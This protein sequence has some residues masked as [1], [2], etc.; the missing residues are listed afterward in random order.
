MTV[1]D[2]IV[3]APGKAQDGETITVMLSGKTVGCLAHD[4]AVH[5]S[6]MS[7]SAMTSWYGKWPS[8]AMASSV[9]L[10]GVEVCYFHCPWSSAERYTHV[11]VIRRPKTLTEDAIA[12]SLCAMS[13]KCF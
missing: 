4:V 12:W 1:S 13:G 3:L 5:V 6:L 11:Q 7:T 10:D 8:C 2:K 9:E